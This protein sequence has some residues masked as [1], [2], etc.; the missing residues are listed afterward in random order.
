MAQADLA[1]V[2]ERRYRVEFEEE[3][4]VA[5]GEGV[6]ESLA[7]ALAGGDAVV[8]HD[9]SEAVA[10]AA[11]G[12]A[13][14][15]ES[16]G[17]KVLG[18]RACGGEGCK[19]VEWVVET[20]GWLAERGASRATTV[21]VLGGGALLDSAGFAAATF[22]RGLPTV[23]VPTTTLA[24]FDAAAGGKTAVNL[25]G[26]NVVGAFHNPK[27]IL[28]EPSL[29]IGL[30]ER[31]FRSGFAEAVKHALLAGREGM[32][33]LDALAGRALMRDP[34][35]LAR[36]ALWSLDFKMSVVV[37][38]PRERGLRRIL[39]LGHTVGHVVEAASGYE[40]THGEAVSIGLA[41]EL[42]LSV[43]EEGLDSS[44][45]EWAVGMLESLGLPTRPPAGVA[46]RALREAPRL[47]LLDKKR[48]GRSIV[49]PLL[50]EPGRPV[51]REVP[52]ERLLGLMEAEW[53]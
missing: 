5:A 8:I 40:L 36:L 52:L 39:N 41:T 21:F 13:E 43:E 22:M 19:S 38:D 28:V 3:T 34:G 35:A 30:P 25:G 49:M 12:L 32:D 26:K 7:P 51:L 9:P 11:A 24:A 10:K 50:R 33:L 44:V 37:R 15:L 20:W 48:V 17:V 14:A 1:G 47:L 2:E 6:L 4:L 23:L 31:P 29:L 27:A 53:R 18:L 16:S 42:R 45:V 46:E